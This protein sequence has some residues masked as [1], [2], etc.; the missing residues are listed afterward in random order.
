MLPTHSLLPSNGNIHNSK[1]NLNPKCWHASILKKIGH[2][3]ES[4]LLAL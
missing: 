1:R 4:N 3:A 2:N